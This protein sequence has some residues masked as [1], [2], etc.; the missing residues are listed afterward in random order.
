VP[1]RGAGRAI[2]DDQGHV[3]TAFSNDLAHAACR[4]RHH[5]YAGA[6]DDKTRANIA[7]HTTMDESYKV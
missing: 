1:Y 5:K 2:N 3:K 7:E 4:S 6:I